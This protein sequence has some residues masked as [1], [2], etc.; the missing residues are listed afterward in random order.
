[1][2]RT[3]PDK[4]VAAI[5]PL[6]ITVAPG[7]V[8]QPMTLGFI[9]TPTIGAN[10]KNPGNLASKL[11]EYQW[12]KI[13]DDADQTS[14]NEW[15]RVESWMGIKKASQNDSPWDADLYGANRWPMPYHH[16]ASSGGA[17]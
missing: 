7:V 2:S 10:A 3:N 14:A 1:M 9:D 4:A 17:A 12:L 15:Q 8:I 6:P 13:Q 16:N 11:S 5:L